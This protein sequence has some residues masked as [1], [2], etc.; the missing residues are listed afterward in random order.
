[1]ADTINVGAL[2]GALQRYV[3]GK[4]MDLPQNELTTP[5]LNTKYLET[6]SLPLHNGSVIEF[7]RFGRLPM[8]PESATSDSPKEFLVDED[9]PERLTMNAEV[10]R[11]GPSFLKTVVQ[12][13]PGG[14]LH[15][16]TQIAVKV[17]EELRIWTRRMTHRLVND[18]FVR[19]NTKT[20]SDVDGND[21]PQEK[22]PKPFRT[23]L[24][25]GLG[26]WG[27][28]NANSVLTMADFRRAAAILEN[29]KAPTFGGRYV[30]FCS[31]GVIA[32]LA[33]EDKQ[34]RYLLE[35]SQDKTTLK[36]G[37]HT[38]ITWDERLIFVPIDDWYACDLPEQGGSL[39]NRRDSGMVHVCH[40]MG[41]KAAAY[42]DWGG[43]G[44]EKG[45]YINRRALTP[46]LKVQ[47]ITTTG[48]LKTLGVTQSAQA[49]TLN[50]QWGL[51]LAGITHFA[52]TTTDVPVINI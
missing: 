3:N 51:N 50:D 26:A 12:I 32:Q 43:G 15:D 41:K 52:E 27:N 44:N 21:V 4:W 36:W 14:L 16:V 49:M 46:K 39:V 5:L 18:R 8:V 19:P 7:R 38:Q 40:M 13:K 37:E 23:M 34:F 1:M 17:E 28:L 2:E 42:L 48:T 29:S 35:K 20:L 45:A 6:A 11:C 22:R 31:P 47:D 30:V 33:N 25:G 24:A 9:P 10:F